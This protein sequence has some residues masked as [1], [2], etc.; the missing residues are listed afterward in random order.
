MTDAAPVEETDVVIVGAGPTGLSAAV[1]LAQFGVAHVVLDTRLEATQTSNAAL[2]HASTLE[3]LTEVGVGDQLVDAGRIA[4]RIVLADRGRPIGRIGLTDIPSRYP[5]ALGVPQST[6]EEL[7]T[8]R[9]SQLGGIVRRG[10]RVDTVRAAGG[11][12]IVAGATENGMPCPV[13]LGARY[14]VGADG[15]HSTVRS[16][17]GLDFAGETYPEQFVLADAALTR[18]P[19]ADDEV[20]INMSAHG[21]TVLGTLPSGNHRVVATVHDSAAVPQTPDMEYLN[22]LFRARGITAQLDGEPAWSSRFKVHHRIAESFRRGGVFLAGD[23]A[24]VHSPAGGQG[25]NTGIA[26]AYDLATRLAAVLTDN[27]KPDVLDDYEPDRLAAAQEVL[28]F[29]DAMTRMATLDSLPGR[30]IRRIVAG[31]LPRIPPIRNALTQSVTGLK[32]SPLRHN[33][34]TVTRM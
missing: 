2:I 21:V 8:R 23:A 33:L 22:S 28:K 5:F 19:N 32:R 4:R 14:I 24:H 29:T 12:Y 10:C 27:A 11:G 25:M 3:L 26:D 17:L 1:R 18:A 31:T 7:L 30:L 9:F 16:L 15:A 20:S 6:T 13:A 34:P